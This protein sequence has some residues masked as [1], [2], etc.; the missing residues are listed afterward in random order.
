MIALFRDCMSMY[1]PNILDEEDE[2]RWREAF[3]N[4]DEDAFTRLLD[5][6]TSRAC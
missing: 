4:S 3:D 5:A 6:D 2:K 1:G